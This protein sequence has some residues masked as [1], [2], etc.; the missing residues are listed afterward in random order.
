MLLAVVDHP[1]QRIVDPGELAPA[2]VGEY[3]DR[4]DVGLGG[5]ADVVA[6]GGDD[7]ADVGAVSLPV[8]GVVHVAVVVG[9]EVPLCDDAPGEVHVRGVQARVQHGHG[10]PCA[11]N[12]ERVA[13][14]ADPEK[15]VHFREKAELGGFELGRLV[16]RRDSE[17]GFFLLSHDSSPLLP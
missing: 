1:L 15:A 6:V 5:D 14:L 3:F 8:G 4:D 16:D 2:L 11:R 13:R 17:C 9:R 12:I 7:A 10:Q